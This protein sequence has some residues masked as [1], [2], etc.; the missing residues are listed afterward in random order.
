MTYLLLF[1]AIV[2]NGI[3]S[4]VFKGCSEKNKNINTYAYTGLVALFSMLFF[5]VASKGK[6]EFDPGSAIYSAAFALCYILSVLGNA[7]AIECGPLSLS[8]LVL[9]CSLIIP[10]MYGFVILK[11]EISVFAKIGI[12]LIFLCSGQPAQIIVGYC[13]MF[14]MLFTVN[15]ISYDEF[16]HGYLFLF[17]LPVTRK[18]YVLEKYVFMMLCGGGFWAVSAAAGFVADYIR[19]DVVSLLE[20]LMPMF[21]ILLEMTIFLAVMLPVSLKYGMEKSRTATMILGFAVLGAAIAARKL[22]PENYAGGLRW[23][24]QLNPAAV[25][26]VV[27]LVSL[28]TLAVSFAGSVRIMQK[29]VF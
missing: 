13:T 29:K 18:D 5:V 9:Q 19:G 2:A 17:T 21:L 8:T 3:Q 23:S 6:F 11:E 20:W 28:A 16:D 10:T 15:T 26:V 24:A 1:A 22:L 25:T 14:G 27:F 12:A 7:K 4:T